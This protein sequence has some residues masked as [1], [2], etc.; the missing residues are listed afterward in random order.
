M[1][2]NPITPDEVNKQF[3]ENKN[4]RIPPEVIEIFNELIVKHW[5]GEKARFTQDAVVS[6]IMKKFKLNT[7]NKIFDENWL[8]IEAIFLT[9]G[10]LVSYFKKGVYDSLTSYF[11]FIPCDD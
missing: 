4:N 7:S 10:W 8:N 11:E 3:S 2:T 9:S 1:M 5:N 6:E